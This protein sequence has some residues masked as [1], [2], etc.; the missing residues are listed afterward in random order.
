MRALGPRRWLL[1]AA[2]AALLTG[3]GAARAPAPRPSGRVL[4]GQACAAC[5]SLSGVED[6]RRQGG[7]LLHFHATRT[8][9][10]ELTAE[11][12]VRRTLTEAQ[13]RAVVG[14]VLAVERRGR[15]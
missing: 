3:C 1:A 2:T 13:L 11:M 10:H 15:A 9:L 6:P 5:H 8:Q 4:F 7:D 14:Y 12:P